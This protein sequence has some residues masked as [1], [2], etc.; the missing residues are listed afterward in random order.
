MDRRA[1]DVA[2]QLL[3][4]RRRCTDNVN[5]RRQ[6]HRHRANIYCGFRCHRDLPCGYTIPLG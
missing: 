4:R 2:M 1:D 6:P 5:V 3:C